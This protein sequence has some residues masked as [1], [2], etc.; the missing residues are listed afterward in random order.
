[1]LELNELKLRPLKE[2]DS[3]L[4]FKWRNEIQYIKNTKSFRLPKH[5]GLEEEWIKRVMVDKSDQAVLFMMTVNDVAIGIIQLSNIDWISKNCY[6]GIAICE[7]DFKGKGYAKT[8]M[9]LLFDYAFKQL[10]IH[11]ISLE[12]TAFN[13]NSIGLYEKFGFIKEGTLKEHYFWDR[14]YHD[15]HLYGLFS[16][17]YE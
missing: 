13:T 6:F 15:V 5:E 16:R 7:D 2:S 9:K 12:V 17:D 14:T 11:K 4:L 3:E 8:S 10:N 1:M